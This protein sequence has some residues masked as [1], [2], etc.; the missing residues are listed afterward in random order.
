MAKKI[1]QP[2]NMAITTPVPLTAIQPAQPTSDPFLMMI[3]RAAATS[4]IATIERLYALREHDVLRHDEQEFNQAMNR[5]QSTIRN[6]APDLENPQ[7]HSKYASF[8]A[9][10]KVIRPVYTAEGVSLSFD[11]ADSPL[12]DHVRVICY[13]SKGAYTRTYR[14]DMPC[15]G[16]GA[17]GGDVMTKTHA[18]SSAKSYGSRYILKNMFAIAIGQDDRDGNEVQPLITEEEAKYLR[19]R[20]SEEGIDEAQLL[21]ACK[22]E[23]LEQILGC[24]FVHVVNKMDER[25]TRLATQREVGQ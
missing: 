22:V 9:I 24:N 3:E 10:D 7:T 18:R 4:D 25:R 17:K 6:V 13:A 19:E 1:R 23:S 20:I 12:L 5:I 11:E 15:D 21:K 16:K 8:D 14:C 2:N